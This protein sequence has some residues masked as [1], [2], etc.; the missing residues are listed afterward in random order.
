MGSCYSGL[1]L[2]LVF[3]LLMSKA[4]VIC[5]IKP[6]VTEVV[7][8]QVSS[9]GFSYAHIVVLNAF[10][11]LKERLPLMSC[12]THWESQVVL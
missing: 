5:E 6:H 11:R 12:V 1:N 4:I 10:F 3:V 9:C 7:Y 2:S 8:I